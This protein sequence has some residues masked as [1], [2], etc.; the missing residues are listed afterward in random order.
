M[1]I[2][3][4]WLTVAALLLL[5]GYFASGAYFVQPDERGVVRWFGR[6][7]D[8]YRRVPPGLRYALPWPFCK[9]DR[10]KT[11]EVRRVF[12]GLPP[13]QRNAIAQGDRDAISNTLASD[14]LTGDVNVLKVT[15]VVQY[16]VTD[17]A[18]YLFGAEN[19]EKLVRATV[20]SVLIEALAGLPVDQALTI[21]KAKLQMETLNDSQRRLDR[22]GCG[23]HLVAT[24]LE[25]IEP[26]RAIVT[27]FQDVVS[28]KKDGERAA[29]QAVSE[30]NRILPKARGE[31]AKL[32][33]EAEGFR[34]TRVSRARGEAARFLNVLA[35]YRQD[36]EAFRQRVLLQTLETVL[37][38]IRTYI[39][40]EKPGDP[41][42]SVRIVEYKGE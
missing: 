27:T 7:P 31:A 18:L 20:Q 19:P 3:R 28:A 37:P 21:A 16:Q 22:Y 13:E 6:L 29:D 36:P 41:R 2:R 9:V 24:N 15:M 12:V 32:L 33:V 40:D 14:M 34:E 42:M 17:P 1:R 4:T 26:P 10:P 8:A 25:T 5:A 11:T 38:K 39:L 30:A 35:A 23:V